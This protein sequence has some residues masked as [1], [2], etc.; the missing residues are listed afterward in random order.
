MTS[1]ILDGLNEVQKKAVQTTDGQV[2]ILAGAGSGKTNVLTRRIAFLIA[3]RRVSPFHIL[4]V[5]FT[6][7]AAGEMKERVEKLIGPDS[8]RISIGT[9]HAI[10]GKILRYEAE[11]LGYK[12]SY[13]IYDSEDQLNLIKVSM[14]F[15]NI[16]QELFAPSMIRSKI[17]KAKNL[18]QGPEMMKSKADNPIDEK[19]ATIYG[20]YERRLQKAN[21]FDFDDLIIKPIQLFHEFP[22]TLTFYQDKFRFIHIDEYQDTN[23]AQYILIQLLAQGHR[24]ICVVG[25]DDQ[26]IYGWR[27]ADIGNILNFEKDYPEAVVFKLEQN[28]RST[29]NIL[30]TANE[31]VKN[32]LNRKSKTLWTDKDAGT[33]VTVLECPDDR[34]EARH[35]VQVIQEKIRSQKYTFADFAI[36]YRTNAQSRLIEESLMHASLPYVMVGG[37]RFYERK[38]IK[39]ILAYLRVI[40][41][42]SDT[43]SLKRIINYPARGI[44]KTTL[45][46]LEE[47]SEARN[48]TLFETL[49]QVRQLGSGWLQ[50]RA[51]SAIQH[52]TEM[53]N[54]YRE[55]KEQL[56]F[57]EW[58]R[59][60]IEEL[61]LLRMLKQENTI[62]AMSRYENIIELMTAI[63]EFGTSYVP[64]AEAETTLDAFLKDVALI[65][66][67]D[68][69][70][71]S[72]N[73]LTLMTIHS[74]KG[75]EFPVVI[76]TG[77][78]EGLFPI[79]TD[80][81]KDLEEERRLFYVGAT[82]AKKDLYLAFAKRRMR[83]NNVYSTTQSRFI[84]EIPSELVNWERSAPSLG[85]GMNTYPHRPRTRGGLSRSIRETS[86]TMVESAYN[87]NS[88]YRAGQHVEHP[89]F[90]P[91]RITEMEGVGDRQKVTI[92]FNDGVERRLMVKYANLMVR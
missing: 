9:F 87:R 84:D 17:T 88:H 16:S 77:V 66:D 24:N 60:L 31:V 67:I 90:G 11:K 1:P 74:S 72:K 76:L 2:L 86:D 57:S 65:A 56:S 79:D 49:M 43:V 91:G 68:Q 73:A 7:K 42:V 33:L 8:R 12:S 92:L 71:D 23:R 27:H 54:K 89:T 46:R 20:E 32:N 37:L 69:F 26:S 25:D 75:L 50:E 15:L 44:G 41:N 30:R 28:Y 38:E 63:G 53:I 70:D 19:A 82:R 3:E 39:D 80:S 21:A 6:N 35:V 78:E 85:L 81:Q 36:L 52:F 59:I 22:D 61:G 34:A 51:L 64:S 62:E 14:E 5:T 29:Q 40:A 83:Y 47:F 45:E 18:F 13:T 48:L 55:L 10:F 4:A 58:T